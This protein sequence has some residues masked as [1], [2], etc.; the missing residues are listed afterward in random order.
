MSVKWRVSAVV[1]IGIIA[2]GFAMSASAKGKPP[3]GPGSFSVGC[4]LN[5]STLQMDEGL[6]SSEAPAVV[7]ISPA[8]LWPPNHKFRNMTLSMSLVAD[9]SSSVE[10]SL[11]VK[12]MTDDQIADDDAGDAGCGPP[13]SEQG[14]DWNPTDFSSLNA[15]GSLQTTGD[16]VSI[17][18]IQL[19]SERCAKDGTRT[20]EVSITCCDISNGVCDATPE[21]LDVTV[22][23]NRG[24]KG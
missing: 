22:H 9:S 20:Y 16:V 8:T 5:D 6:T 13:T 4:L 11:T 12:D 23:K 21:V 7:T 17:P 18:G 24:H 15:S 19:R 2:I 10:T 1:V 14:A 3:K